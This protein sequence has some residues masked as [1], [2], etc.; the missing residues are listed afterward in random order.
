MSQLRTT[1]SSRAEPSPG[2][3]VLLGYHE[4][5]GRVRTLRQLVSRRAF[6]IFEARGGSVG[7]DLADW[8]RA[9]S[10]LFHVAHLDL[11]ES[12]EA[13]LVHAET[14]GFA[15]NELEIAIEPRRLT[16]TGHRVPRRN[17]SSHRVIYQD[18]CSN[19]IFRVVDL[20][21]EV[22]PASARA[23]SKDGA[24]ELVVTKV[25]TSS[26]GWIVRAADYKAWAE[27]FARPRSSTIPK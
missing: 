17:P 26:A 1:T 8:F 14:P 7:N 2:P 27:P 24:V 19:R 3:K 5:L 11:A 22:D 6:E 15:P 20:P 23:I 12:S 16:I 10:E 9:E 21:I 4:I 25:I 13:L 18:S